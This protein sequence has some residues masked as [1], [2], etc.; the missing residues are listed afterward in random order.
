MYTIE[1]YLEENMSSIPSL[2]HELEKETW[3]KV[4]NPR[5]CSG[6]Y[7][8]RVLSA[9]SKMIRP[10]NILEIGTYTGY[11][12]L[13]L[14]EG[15]LSGG[16]LISMDV[17]DEL[18]WIHD[19]YLRNQPIQIMYGDAHE[20]LNEV[21]LDGVDLVFVDADKSGYMQYCLWLEKHL[22]TGTWVL[23]DNVLWNGKVLEETAPKD[24]DTAVLKELNGHLA[25]SS[26]W[27]VVIL[28]IRDGLTLSRKL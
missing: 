14:S 3:Q 13:C 26:E 9:L 10:R 22:A 1:T 27:E 17:N 12:A 21:H 18:K 8:G 23:W 25:Q 20:K 6:A 7:Q 28:P 19:K 16:T 24:I 15:L 11:S 4:I 2:L 5:M